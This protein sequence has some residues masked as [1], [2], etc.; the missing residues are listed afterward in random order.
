MIKEMSDVQIL[1]TV[2]IPN[3][4]VKYLHLVDLDSCNVVI[5]ELDIGNT[6]PHSSFLFHRTYV[7]GVFPTLFTS[8]LKLIEELVLDVTWRHE[9][10]R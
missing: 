6:L 10:D 3:K 5:S 1:R 7:R 8:C 9:S 4:Y 2:Q